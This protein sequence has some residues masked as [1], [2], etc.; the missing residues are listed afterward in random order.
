M[1]NKQGIRNVLSL[2]VDS[3]SPTIIL[4][5]EQ[6]TAR[7]NYVCGFIFSHVL[8]L[9]F[10]IT[11]S[12]E[13]LE[14]SH[15]YKINYSPE[16]IDGTLQVIPSGLLSE[17]NVSDQKPDVVK[18]GGSVYFYPNS[19]GDL[20]FDVFSAVFY[21]ISRYEEWQGF[22]ADK[23]GRF[24]INQSILFT[25]K[26]ETKPVVDAWIME[27]RKC[28][29]GFFSGIV[30]PVLKTKTI[31]TIDVDN[32]SAYSDKG[33]TRTAGAFSRDVLK[34]DLGNIK[35]RI[36]VLGGKEKDPFHIYERITKFC[37]SINVPVFYF[38]LYRTGTAFDRAVDP[39]SNA[40]KQAIDEVVANG[41]YVGIHPSYYTSGNPKLM[42]EEI[43]AFSKTVGTAITVSRQHYLRF[44][45]KTTPKHLIE[46]GIRADFTMGFA[47][48]PGFRAGTTH[49]FYY[50]DFVH[51][52]ETELLFVPFCAMDGAYTVYDKKSPEAALRKFQEIKAEIEKVHGLFITVFHERTFADHLYPGYGEL[53]KSLLK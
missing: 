20:K 48:A 39:G 37:K 14:A 22:E 38:F 4:Y 25:H 32:L 2:D 47:S 31:S 11:S 43:T 27:L 50:F 18:K 28:I 30:L 24:E 19:E 13:D 6:V 1:I 10:I 15:F 42:R 52:K 49:P 41:G 36:K 8:K 5:S 16:I 9:K 17:T 29:A 45:I 7:L 21:M 33:F 23:H 46:N 3:S 12:K 35:R 51:E 53:F 26:T 34:G 40:F 44:D